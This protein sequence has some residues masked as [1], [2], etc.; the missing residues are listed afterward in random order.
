MKISPV[1]EYTSNKFTIS[2]IWIPVMKVAYF[3]KTSKH[4]FLPNPLK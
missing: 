1:F 4:V 3:L 2:E